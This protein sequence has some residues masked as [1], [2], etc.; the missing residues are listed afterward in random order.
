MTKPI[1]RHVQAILEG[2][3]LSSGGLEWLQDGFLVHIKTGVALHKCL[4]LKRRSYMITIRNHHLMRALA[5]INPDYSNRRRIGILQDEINMLFKIWLECE[6]L[7]K[8]D[9]RWSCLRQEIF[10]ALRCH[11]GI[12]DIRQLEN[13]A[14]SNSDSIS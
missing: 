11:V 10:L 1:D 9:P 13:I 6:A 14:K 8:P 2:R 5:Q 7:T 12:P 4:G 3:P